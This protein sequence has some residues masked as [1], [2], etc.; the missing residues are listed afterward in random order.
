[1]TLSVEPSSE[2]RRAAAAQPAGIESP[3]RDRAQG[4]NAPAGGR[5]PDFFIV[6]HPKCGTTALHGMLS[7]HPQVYMPALKEPRF[8]AHD[9]YGPARGAREGKLPDTLEG[10]LGLFDGAGAGQRAGE[11]SPLYLA[12][13]TA[14]EEIARLQPAARIVAILREPAS[15]L[16][17]L[18]LQ[19][20]E[21]HIEPKNDLGRAIALEDARRRGRRMPR[22]LRFRPHVLLYSEHVR[23]VE[24]LR[25][26]HAVFPPEQVLVLIYEDFRSDNEGTVRR[27][28]RF[29]GA[30]EHVPVEAM[31]A[32]PTVRV[33]SRSLDEMVRAISLGSGPVSRSAKALI[34]ALAPADLRRAALATVWRRVV[35]GRPRPPDERLAAELRRRF[36]GEVVALSEYLDRDLVSLWGYDEI[37]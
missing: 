21:S 10:Y 25:R 15:F 22:S 12:S 7:G 37:G 13:R 1:M 14:A 4:A 33:R 9:M 18:H 36:R 20:V 32:N 34:K 24:Q 8:F 30:D 27:V 31:E 2:P 23:Y 26:Y 11:A 16:R 29:L 6:G 35:Y 17:S 5:L 28:L 19:F 3:A